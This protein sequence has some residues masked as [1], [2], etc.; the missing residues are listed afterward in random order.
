MSKDTRNVGLAFLFSALIVSAISS[1]SYIFVLVP[2]QAEMLLC[3][4]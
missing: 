3:K 2:A 4:L 1:L